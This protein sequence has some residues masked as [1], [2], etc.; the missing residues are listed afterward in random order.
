MKDHIQVLS[1]FS[2][3]FALILLAAAIG[4]PAW[5]QQAQSTAADT[6]ANPPSAEQQQALPPVTVPPAPKEGFW[7]RINPFARKV[8]VKKRIDPINDQL[9]EL[10]Q[11]D[12]NEAHAIKD[13]DARAQAGIRKA[14]SSADVANQQAQA[15]GSQAQSANSTAQQASSHVSQLNTTV[16]GLDQ[17]RP[18]SAVDVNFRGASPVL[19]ES[20][21]KQLD[22]LAA[23]LA[24]RDGY[25][26]EME[27]H[28]PAAGGAGIQISQRQAEAVERYLVVEHQIPIYRMHSVALGNAPVAS[29]GDEIAPERTMTSSVQ[30]R[31]MENSLAAQAAVPP[32]DTAA[33]SGAGQP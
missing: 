20:A 25:I 16:N 23:G 4:V 7:G 24:G 26:L 14:Q 5:T 32:Q 29:A 31:L 27:A 1:S 10:D 6:Q 18:V 15:A 12:A 22:D 11:V 17:Y 19:T 13:V 33:S 21:R 9:N 28:T 30:I 8:W 3:Q 2:R